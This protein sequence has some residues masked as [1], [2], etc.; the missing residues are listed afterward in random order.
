MAIKV[1]HL[2]PE[3]VDPRG[4]ITRL[5]NEPKI[6]VRA[7]LLLT[8]KKNTIRGNHI[9]KKDSHWVYCVSGKFRYYEQDLSKKNSKPLSVI[10]KPG[11]L[12]YSK[13]GIAHAMKAIENTVFLAITTEKR[14]QKAYEADLVRVDIVGKKK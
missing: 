9:H 11:D 2:K 13:P 4:A 7:V 8:H 12:V 1:T 14:Q 6:Q 3:F 10:L 5:I